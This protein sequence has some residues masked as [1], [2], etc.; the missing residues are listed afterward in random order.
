MGLDKSHSVSVLLVSFNTRELTLACLH[1]VYEQT[2]GAPFEVIV[3][4][5]ASTDGSAAAIAAQ[6]PGVRLIASEVNLGFAAANN[7]AAR[8]ATGRYILL[9]NPDTVILDGAIDTILDFAERNPEY[10]VYGGRTLFADGQL[11]PTSCW[12][13]MSLWSLFCNACGLRRLLPSSELFNNEGIGCWQRDSVREVGV[14]TGCFLLITTGLWRVLGG[15]NPKYFMYA[16]EA[17]LC[18]RAKALGARPVIVPEAT[19]IHYGS[20]SDP[21]AWEKQV[22][23]LQGKVT[24]MRDHW[25]LVARF[26]GIRLLTYRALNHFVVYTILSSVTGKD[27][28]RKRSQTFLEIWKSRKT[29]QKGY[30]LDSSDA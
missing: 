10:K 4:D 11:N 17:D 20:A 3:V 2:Q 15:F 27:E 7:L 24:L 1:S 29:W 12:G 6:F 18:L 13:Q 21:I 5:N 23:V 26:L 9:L 14:V 28:Y 22:K 16:E 25:G 19:I 8:E 30:V